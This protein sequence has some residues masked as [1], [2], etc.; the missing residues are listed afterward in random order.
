MSEQFFD[1]LASGDPSLCHLHTSGTSYLL[2]R[3]AKSPDFDYLF[4]ERRYRDNGLTRDSSFKYAGIYCK[5]DGL[6]YDAQYDLKSLDHELGTMA[7]KSAG[8]LSE[9]LKAVVRQRVETAVGNDRCNLHISEL[10]ESRLLNSLDYARQHGAK[11]EARKRYLDTV[12]FEPPA[13]RCFYDPDHWTEDSLLDYILDP[14][15]YADKEAAAYLAGHQEDILYSFL[16][17]DLVLVEY[18]AIWADPSNP[19]HYI[20]KISEAMRT[21]EAKTVNVTI[22]KEGIEFTFKTE[23]HALRGDCGRHYNSWNIV[24]ADRREFEQLF[25]RSAEYYPEEV[26]RIT[27]SRAIL[28][29]RQA[30][31]LTYS[32]DLCGERR[33]FDQGINWLTS[34]FGVCDQ[35]YEK[36]SE[37]EK[38]RLR[39]EHE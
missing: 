2:L 32:C 7:D 39:A 1:W 38:E 33:D 9:Q 35:C 5:R 21:T 28:Y 29:E 34:S 22:C 30:E 23:A 3:L 31:V 36:L 13:Y 10:T 24:S 27:Y 4:C 25:G 12:E 18:R 37:E 16:H 26:V 17:D 14:E 19:V 20:K 8:V 15:G 6:L 11:D